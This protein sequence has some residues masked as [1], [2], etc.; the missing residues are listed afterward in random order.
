MEG[1]FQKTGFS[2]NQ[3]CGDVR[4]KLV[5][6]LRSKGLQ[7]SAYAHALITSMG[8]KAQVCKNLQTTF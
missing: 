2:D 4:F 7:T 6:A 1:L 8:S 5:E 3:V